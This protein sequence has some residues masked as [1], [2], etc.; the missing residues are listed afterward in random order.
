[1]TDKSVADRIYM[2]PL[3]LEFMARIIE[4]NG[5]TPSCPA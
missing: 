5:R 1:M 2:E 3:T 4:R